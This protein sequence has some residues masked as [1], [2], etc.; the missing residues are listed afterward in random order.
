MIGNAAAIGYPVTA[1]PMGSPMSPSSAPSGS[2]PRLPGEP[3]FLLVG[4]IGL[5]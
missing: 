4:V 3:L 2:G 1:S 5:S